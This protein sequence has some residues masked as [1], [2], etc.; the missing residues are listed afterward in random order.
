MSIISEEPY[1]PWE[2][3]IPYEK[4]SQA[5]RPLGVELAIGRWITETTLHRRN[6]FKSGTAKLFLPR[7]RN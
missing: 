4:P 7:P 6:A 5:R 3:I 2:L 1:I